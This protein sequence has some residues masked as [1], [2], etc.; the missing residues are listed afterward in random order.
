MKG[1]YADIIVDIAHEK[2]DRTFSY[3]VPESLKDSVD[4]GSAVMIP[5]GRGDRLI[6][7]YIVSFS[8]TSD[9]DESRLK[10]INDVIDENNGIDDRMVKLA[11][12]MRARYGGTLIQSLKTVLPMRKKAA[13]IE[14]RTVIRTADTESIT[15]EYGECIRKHRTAQARLLNE[16]R[17]AESLPYELLTGKLGVSAQTIKALEARELIRIERSLSYRNPVKLKDGSAGELLLSKEQLNITDSYKEA[18][19]RGESVK[20]LIHGITGSGKTNVYIKLIDDALKAGGQAIV[21]IPEIALTYQ[22]LKRFYSHFGERV[23]VLNSTLSPAEKYDQCKRAENGEIDIMIGPRSAL[24]TPF[25]KLKLIII[26]EEHENSYKSEMTPKYHARD[27]AIR[28]S[29]LSGASIVLGSATPSVDAYYKAK[30][31]EFTLFTL[32]ERHTGQTLPDVWVADMRDEL[33]AGNKSMFSRR[34]S[35]LIE[36]RLS[37][38]EQSMLFLNRRGYAGFISCRECGEVIKCIHCDVSLSL[39]KNGMLVCH[40]CGYEIPRPRLC[41]KCN[42]KYIG[43]F[44]AGTEQ[45]EEKLKMLYPG[46]RTLRMDGDTTKKKDS[47]E[48]ILSAFANNEADVLIGTQMIVKGHDFPNVT[49]VGVI[50]ADMSLNAQ[51]YTAGERTFELLVQAVGRA[52]RGDKKGEAVIQTYQPEHYAV[53]CAQNQDYEGFYEE[54]IAFREICG[55]PPAAHMLSVMIMGKYEESVKSLAETLALVVKCDRDFKVVGPAPAAIGKIND[56]YRYVFYM[57]DESE[58]K[59]LSARERI[60]DEIKKLSPTEQIQFDFI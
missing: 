41:P 52:G 47:Y 23:S 56:V 44:K 11:A 45:V 28:L 6:K 40:Y 18:L 59:L 36:D 60:E 37:K 15:A 42:S 13:Q 17:E 5:F 26:D 7:G 12:Y 14:H 2:L 19:T 1:K 57:K 46:I 48:N 25:K 50:A 32:K 34:L 43:E 9:Y 29:E 58:R 22:T 30:A 39:H 55:Y 3:I 31:G 21:L 16:L 20:Y 51:E 27:V 33:M 8:D 10:C 4:I 38:G 53:L 54:E 35:A 24:F 49:C